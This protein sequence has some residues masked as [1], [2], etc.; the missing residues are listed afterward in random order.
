MISLT[1][2]GFSFGFSFATPT[3]M[4]VLYVIFCNLEDKYNPLAWWK[5]YN[6]ELPV[7]P[8]LPK[9]TW[10]CKQVLLYLKE[11][12]S[13][14][15][16]SFPTAALQWTPRLQKKICLCQRTGTIGIMWTC[17]R[18]YMKKK[19]K[20]RR[21]VKINVTQGLQVCIRSRNIK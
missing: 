2:F 9:S 13:R 10:L 8:S 3:K 18:L 1:G 6:A 11:F 17:L 14:L 5:P 16:F 20:R 21:K 12:L 15:H 7:L 19:I 4:L